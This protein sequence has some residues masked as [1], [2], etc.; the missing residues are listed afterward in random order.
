MTREELQSVLDLHTRAYETV[1]WLHNYSYAHPELLTEQTATALLDEAACRSWAIEN[2][3]RIPHRLRP[4]GAD[5]EKFACLFASFFQTSFRI[6]R[7]Q[8]YGDPP[9][10]KVVAAKDL[11]D[12]K[13]PFAARGRV[14]RPTK[15]KRQQEL[16][17]LKREALR[18]LAS[19]APED[20]M[21]AVLNE[22]ALAAD[23]ALWSYAF[24][25]VARSCGRPHGP[26]GH[27]LWRELDEELRKNLSADTIWSARERLLAKL[28]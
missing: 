20:R 21:D 26:A 4:A 19:E 5:V 23:V 11:A 24:D 18:A 9:H 2:I 17:S 12:R 25:L 1:L 28:M 7:R 14:S 13:D 10:F 16:T 3:D 15:R 27:L 22:S 8:A 6:E